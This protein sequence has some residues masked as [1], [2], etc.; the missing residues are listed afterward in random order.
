MRVLREGWADA[1]KCCPEEQ[2]LTDSNRRG[3][4]AHHKKYE[5]G[6]GGAGATEGDQKREIPTRLQTSCNS[7]INRPKRGDH[8]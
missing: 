5:V 4:A 3:Q 1:S 8:Y 2:C 6:D 7:R